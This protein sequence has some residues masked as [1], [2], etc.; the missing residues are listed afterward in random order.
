MVMKNYSE[1][2]SLSHIFQILE[3]VSY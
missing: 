1:K 2:R 3:V